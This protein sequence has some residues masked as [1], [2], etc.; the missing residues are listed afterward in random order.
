[1]ISRRINMAK[2]Y[3]GIAEYRGAATMKQKKRGRAKVQFTYKKAA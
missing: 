2:K 3:F 1:M